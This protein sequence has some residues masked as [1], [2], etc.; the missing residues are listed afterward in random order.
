MK[1]EKSYVDFCA[2]NRHVSRTC[3]MLKHVVDAQAYVVGPG[4]LELC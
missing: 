2:G 3:L 1:D 4:D